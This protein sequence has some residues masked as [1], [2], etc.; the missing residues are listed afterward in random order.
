MII[1]K[2]SLE[3]LRSSFHHAIATD[4]ATSISSEIPIKR[5][6]E[7][8]ACSQTKGAFLL[9]NP[10]LDS[11]NPILVSTFHPLMKI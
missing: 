11:Q 2:S 5:L 8:A 7:P 6:K 10:D 1:S 9:A 3:S 4:V